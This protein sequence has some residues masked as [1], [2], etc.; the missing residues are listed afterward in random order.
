[1]PLYGHDM[2]DDIS[3]KTAG[4]GFV[5]KMDKPDFIGKA[6]LRLQLHSKREELGSRLL[7]AELSSSGGDV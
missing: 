6:A 5:I 7:A 3:P 1:M 2:N 4:L